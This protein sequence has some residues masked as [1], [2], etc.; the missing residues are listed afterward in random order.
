MKKIII[1]IR[2]TPKKLQFFKDAGEETVLNYFTK[3][4]NPLRNKNNFGY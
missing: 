4:K 1:I 2:A 3:N